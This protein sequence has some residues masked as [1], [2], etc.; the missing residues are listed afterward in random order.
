MNAIPRTASLLWALRSYCGS[1]TCKPCYFTWLDQ[2]RVDKT[3]GLLSHF[4]P[5]DLPTEQVM[6]FARTLA[7]SAVRRVFLAGGEPLMWR[8][9]LDL[10]EILKRGGLEVMVCTSGV[11]LNQPGMARRL[12]ELG[13]DGFS[14]SLDSTDPDYNDAWRPPRKDGDG[15]EGVVSGIKTLLAARGPSA[16]PRVGLYTV[17]T[18]LNL[19]DIVGVPQ[20]A[21]DL[22]CD[23]AVPQP[24]A[25][26][27]GHDLYDTLVLT[28]A[29]LPFLEAQ[30]DRLYAAGLPLRL[31]PR[32]YP[33]QV[34]SAVHHLTGTVEGCFGGDT[35]FFAE[36]D[37]S[38]WDCPSSLKM[39]ATPT[40]RHRTIKG[41]DA[42]DL[43]GK[44]SGCGSDCALFGVDC[45]NMW[46]LMDFD[47]VLNTTTSGSP[48]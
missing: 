21:A 4:S 17:I 36:P 8:P 29:E 6:D 11:A 10:I 13:V 40:E 30:F 2:Q 26:P 16:R 33:G 42:A 46:P 28:D 44:P 47:R 22:G 31:P 15:W 9:I 37:G 24:V 39:A 12:V 25:L 20:L 5:H 38:L 27:E 45:V 43:F 32:T 3:P 18:K 1:H 7:G 19:P 48:S 41:A 35:L 14:V 23:Y 34:A